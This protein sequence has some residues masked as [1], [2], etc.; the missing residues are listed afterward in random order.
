[1]V[2]GG[3]DSSEQRRA[4][5][6]RAQIL[7]AH[8]NLELIKC[9]IVLNRYNIRT[10]QPLYWPTFHPELEWAGRFSCFSL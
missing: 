8:D 4:Q 3:H 6:D 5:K 9:Q 1:M 10:P 2:A 7:T